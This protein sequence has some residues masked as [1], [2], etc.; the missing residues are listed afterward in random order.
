MRATRV[1]TERRSTP[2]LSLALLAVAGSALAADFGPGERCDF[3]VSY[4]GI[5]SGRSALRIEPAAG[6]RWTIVFEAGAQGP[7][8]LFKVREESRSLWD[9]VRQRTIEF[10]AISEQG[11]K[12]SRSH[13]VLDEV[14]KK[15]DVVRVRDGKESRMTVPVAAS[16]QDL[17]SMFTYLRTKRLAVGDAET[18]PVLTSKRLTSL[19][20]RVMKRER[21]KTGAG[22]FNAVKVRGFLTAEKREMLFWF[23]DE[24]RHIPLRI[25]AELT[26]GSMK[27]SLTGYSP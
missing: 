7:F 1:H 8:G 20:A 2:A 15:F 26:I 3:D 12:L 9:A 13:A 5:G 19:E 24:P 27:A 14:G 10:R 21:I 16:V 17:A 18:F 4:L 25:E 22:T 11:G 23:S 6:G